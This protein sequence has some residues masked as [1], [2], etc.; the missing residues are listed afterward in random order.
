MLLTLVYSQMLAE[1][2]L[3]R[4]VEEAGM[5]KYDM[6]DARNLIRADK[7][8]D[9]AQMQQTGGK[10]HQGLLEESSKKRIHQPDFILYTLDLVSHT[11]DRQVDRCL[12]NARGHKSRTHFSNRISW[13]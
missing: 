2:K 11:I 1:L 3:Q 6:S 8:E 9:Q 12:S 10:Y 5:R 13:D 7:Q 4:L